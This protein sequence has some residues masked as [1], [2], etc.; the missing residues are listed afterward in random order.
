MFCII[1]LYYITMS[2]LILAHGNYDTLCYDFTSTME[3]HHVKG[4]EIESTEHSV[5]VCVSILMRVCLHLQMIDGVTTEASEKKLNGNDSRVHEC[6]LSSTSTRRYE[7]R[8]KKTVDPMYINI[9]PESKCTPLYMH[10]SA[11]VFYNFYVLASPHNWV[12]FVAIFSLLHACPAPSENSTVDSSVERVVRFFSFFFLV[13]ASCLASF[14]CT[15]LFYVCE[16]LF[17]SC[18]AFFFACAFCCCCCC[19]MCN[20]DTYI[21][22]AFQVGALCKASSFE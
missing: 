17:F 13:L 10:P 3:Q 14:F 19:C 8:P 1:C 12:L 2:R 11:A 15:V 21:W 22:Y 7:R 16:F 6:R 4:Y 20:I 5:C 9:V 18:L